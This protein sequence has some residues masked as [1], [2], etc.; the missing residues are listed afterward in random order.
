MATAKQS[1]PKTLDKALTGIQGLDEISE[2]GLPRG[3]PTLVAGPAGCGKTLLAMQFILSGAIQYNEPG[4]FMSFEETEGDLAKNFQ[5][6]GYDLADLQKRKKIFLDYVYVERSEIEETGEYD[7]EALFIRLGHAIDSIKAKRV[8]LD[9]LETLFGG[10]SNEAILRAELRRL[11]RWLKDR[12]VTAVITGESGVHTF[13]RHGL[14]EYISDCVIFLDNR[15]NNELATR[16]LRMVKY[17]GSAHGTNEFP[18]LIG[19]NGLVVLPITSLH[20]RYD[21]PKQRVSSGLP[22]LDNMLDGKGFFRGSSVLVS[23]TAGTGKT[24]LSATFAEAACERGE[25]CLYFAFEESPAQIIRNMSSIGINLAAPAKTG[26]L[27]FHAIR[28]SVLGLEGHLVQMHELISEFK[29]QVVIVDPISNLVTSVGELA[30][31][32]MLTRLIDF[33][34]QKQITTV[35]T[36]LT[37][38]G[39]ALETSQVGVSSLM[40]TWIMLRDIE[41][42]GERNRGLYI[43]K[44][45]G[46][47]HSNQIREFVLTSKGIDLL[48]V[49]VGPAGVLTGSARISQESRELAESL[50]RT[51]D[52]ERKRNE[53]ERKRKMMEQEIEEMRTQFE[54]QAAELAGI[55]GEAEVREVVREKERSQMGKR[56]GADSA[57]RPA[58]RKGKGA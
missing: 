45:R 15:M 13:T 6:L 55:I 22:R 56:R 35:F 47:A 53:L 31:Q 7:L 50:E 26:L 54:A 57:T 34:K 37:E 29:P 28:P 11:F 41:S 48:D 2:G 32:L 25:R 27:M 40:D 9:S 12:G 5:S 46:M 30:A 44:S 33:L 36:T 18:F 4:V 39:S 51:Q 58:S 14:E 52:I 16:R 8:A 24:S 19:P 23:G 42:G 10:L 17:R 38:Q 43:L 1:V 21:V 3:R 20:L 49:Y